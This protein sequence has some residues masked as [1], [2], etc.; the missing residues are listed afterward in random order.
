MTHP[1]KSIRD[2]IETAL[3][4]LATT[5]TNVFQ[6]RVFPLEDGDLPGLLIYN[7][8]D[9][10]EKGGGV[11]QFDRI[12][13]CMV[14]AV[15]KAASDTIDDTLD[16]IAEQI[17]TAID[18]DRTLSGAC[19]YAWIS[20]TEFEFNVEQDKRVGIARI[21]ITVEYRSAT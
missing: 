21:T 5:G 2:A 1:R 9:V 12:F 4:G 6:N 15:V 13:D 14:D 8:P 17:E 20:N 16:A 11:G 18:A 3:T 10:G 7:G 19:G